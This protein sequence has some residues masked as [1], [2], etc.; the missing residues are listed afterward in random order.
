MAIKF[1]SEEERKKEKEAKK[2]KTQ[3][4][5]WRIVSLVFSILAMLILFLYFIVCF[6]PAIVI[7]PMFFFWFLVV[8][9]PTICSIGLIWT[10]DGY[11]NFAKTITDLLGNS[12][13]GLENAIKVLSNSLSYVGP[14]MAMI[15]MSYLVLSFFNYRKEK[16]NKNLA[17]LIVSGV[18]FIIAL[19]LMIISLVLLPKVKI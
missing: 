7:L 6:N 13:Q 2:P 10:L 17:H 5:K 14:I 12:I 16:N 1:K 15:V 3:L 19:T 4:Q 18:L 9:I 11:Q 8:V